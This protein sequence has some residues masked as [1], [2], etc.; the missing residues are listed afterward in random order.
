MINNHMDKVEQTKNNDVA[1]SEEKRPN[2]NAG[3]YFSSFVKI[4][5][6]NTKEIM[7]QKR[8]DN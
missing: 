3:L 8:G 1:K 7:V 2:E 6:P 5:D 4:H